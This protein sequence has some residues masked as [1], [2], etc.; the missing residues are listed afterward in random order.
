MDVLI[1]AIAIAGG[2]VFFV[3]M[4]GDVPRRRCTHKHT[5]TIRPRRVVHRW[6]VK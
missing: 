5:R 2:I 1:G 6:R 3:V 4:S